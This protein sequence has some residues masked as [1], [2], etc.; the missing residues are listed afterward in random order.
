MAL[1][2]IRDIASEHRYTPATAAKAV[3]SITLIASIGHHYHGR[4]CP[5]TRHDQCE[6]TI[7]WRYCEVSRMRRG[8]YL[9]IVLRGR[10]VVLSAC[11]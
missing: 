6:I 3:Y 5:W 8:W 4:H 9:C 10:P 1:E 11:Y 2:G 7:R